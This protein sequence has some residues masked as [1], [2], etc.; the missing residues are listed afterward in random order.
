[1]TG[2]ITGPTGAT[3]ATGSTEGDASADVVQAAASNTTESLA[4]VLL[5]FLAVL[6][7]VVWY[8]WWRARRGRAQHR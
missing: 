5:V 1:M 8:L 2:A 7:G 4:W 6:G 3:G